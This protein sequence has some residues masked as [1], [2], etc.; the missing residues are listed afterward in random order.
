ML[1][2][3]LLAEPVIRAAEPVNKDDGLFVKTLVS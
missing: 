1:Q 3:S 2:Q